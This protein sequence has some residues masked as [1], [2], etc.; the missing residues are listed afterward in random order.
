VSL[1]AWLGGRTFAS[2]RN[3]RNFRLYFV[4]HGVSFA[5]SW[6]QQIAAYWLVL[7]LTGSPLAVGSLALA[8]LLPVTLFGLFVGSVIDRFDVRRLLL[9]TES[10]LIVTA[11][12]L[13]V[14][15]LT[16]AVELWH[17]Y[18][19][20]TIQGLVS[21]IGNPARHTLVFRIVGEADL[22]NAVALSSALGT[23]ARIA[24]PGLGG[25]VVALAG[26]GVAFAVNSASY[27]AV[28]L[29]LLAMR[30]ADLRPYVPPAVQTGFRRSIRV[31]LSF[32]RRSRRV[33]VAFFAVLALSTVSFNFDVLLPLLAKQTLDSGAD[34]F[35]LI[36][37]VFGAGAL[38]GALFLATIGKASLRLLLGGAGAYGVLELAIAPQ[39]HL[40]A[41][42]VLL[43]L[44]GICYVLWGASAL[45]SLQ[46]AAPEH[47][48]GQA[49][50]LYFFA[51]QGGAPLGGLL[52]GWLTSRGGTSLA[53]TVAGV[54]A[55]LVAVVGAASLLKLQPGAAD[56]DLRTLLLGERRDDLGDAGDIVVADQAVGDE[57]DP[58]RVALHRQDAAL[59]K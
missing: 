38:C 30:T 5:G 40:A 39:G 42:C 50:S 18:V 35:G 11:G 25:L 45:A 37:A 16:G 53:F 48:R 46:L 56:S 17:V 54:A 29:A 32:V 24:G 3:H 22:P 23:M 2:L 12:T 7:E 44:I 47:L 15:T 51:F 6:M 55:V 21:V 59:G 43:F 10:L 14:L 31:M 36:A 49:A 13:A 27:G 28:V 34:V 58:A 33:A 1:L 8:Q 52:A 41:V 19:L 26:T 20:A 9:V 4:S 57:A